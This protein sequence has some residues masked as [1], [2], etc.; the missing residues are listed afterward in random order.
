MHGRKPSIW[1]EFSHKP[2]TTN[3]GATGDVACDHYHLFKDP[4]TGRSYIPRESNL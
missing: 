2:G 4:A 1:D 3:D